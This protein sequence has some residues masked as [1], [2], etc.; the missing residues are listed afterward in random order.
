MTPF[1]LKLWRQLFSVGRSTGAFLVLIICNIIYFLTYFS[2]KDLP[3]VNNFSVIRRKIWDGE[4]YRLITATFTHSNWLHLAFN[5]G[6]WL[7]YARSIEL[8][9]GF[10][11][12]LYLTICSGI[13]AS[14]CQ[15][16]FDSNSILKVDKIHDDKPMIG[17]S[18]AIMSLMGFTISKIRFLYP[19]Y[20]KN[21]II[22]NNYINYIHLRKLNFYL[23]RKFGLTT[24]LIGSGAIF[25]VLLNYFAPSISIANTAHVSG[26]LH[27]LFL[28]NIF[29]FAGANAFYVSSILSTS[30]AIFYAQKPTWSYKYLVWSS[31]K[32]FEQG[33]WMKAKEKL[34][35]II[36]R[37]NGKI[38]IWLTL[39]IIYLKKKINGQ[40][41]Y[42]H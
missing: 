5:C 39:I 22:N 33:N 18:G 34:E 2:E 25:A 17:L 41:H 19:T 8:S 14:S 1:K 26:L 3:I 21:K 7:P 6:V 20:F 10:L 11:P 31:L 16:A 28:G 29:Y 37:S 36:Q 38:H 13:F 4:Y 23:N 32:E 30:L 40:W 24:R 27:G 12:L 15:V 9:L 42:M 35:K